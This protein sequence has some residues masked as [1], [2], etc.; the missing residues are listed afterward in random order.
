MSKELEKHLMT[1]LL[2]EDVEGLVFGV[3]HKDGTFEVGFSQELSYLEQL[4]LAQSIIG[5]VQ[6]EG[7]RSI[8]DMFDE[9]VII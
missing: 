7:Q 2:N 5:D 8:A 1:I 4:G 3:K 9:L 6:A